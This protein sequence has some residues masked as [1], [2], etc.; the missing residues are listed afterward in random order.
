M[1]LHPVATEYHLG[2][3]ALSLAS[4]TIQVWTDHD[5]SDPVVDHLLTDRA[6]IRVLKEVRNALAHPTDYRDKRL[7]RSGEALDQC[8][9]FA[10]EVM[11]AMQTFYLQEIAASPGARAALERGIVAPKI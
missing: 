7:P 11:I 5:F 2:L 1:G 10:N 9:T 4:C 8:W 6:K 3:V